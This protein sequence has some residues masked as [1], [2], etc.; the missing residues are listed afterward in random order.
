M[1]I[2]CLDDSEWWFTKNVKQKKTNSKSLLV[3]IN[4]FLLPGIKKRNIYQ[5]NRIFTGRLDQGR[6]VTS[7]LRKKKNVVQRNCLVENVMTH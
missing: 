6:L 7:S 2:S 3:S 4:N 1:I 5:R